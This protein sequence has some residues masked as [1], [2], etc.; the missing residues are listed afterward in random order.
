MTS[1]FNDILEKGE[2]IIRDFKPNKKRY[3][4]GV[5]YSFFAIF[6]PPV[7]F[8]FLLLT[9]LT[10]GSAFFIFL[11]LAKVSYR[12]THYC[13]TSKRL[14]IRSGIVGVDYKSLEYKDINLTKVKVGF[15]DKKCGTGTLI[16]TSPSA[17]LV[18]GVNFEHI[19]NPYDTLRDIKEHMDRVTQKV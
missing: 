1:V 6:F 10:L 8:I 9:V 2:T 14:I 17:L 4:R 3:W 11:H 19:E 7:T 13:Y 5:R 15:L 12:N 16:F 18:G